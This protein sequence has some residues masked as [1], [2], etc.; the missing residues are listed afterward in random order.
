MKIDPRYSL[1]LAGRIDELRGNG[2]DPGPL[3]GLAVA[4]KDLIAVDGLGCGAGTRIDI[5][6]LLPPEGAFVRGLK[7]AG[8]VIVGKTRTTEFALGGQNL[9]HPTP[10]NPLDEEIE[11]TPGGSSSGSAVAVGEGTVPLSVG[12]DTGGSVRLPA[13][14]CGVVGYKASKGLWGSD[15][16]FPL[17]PTFDSLGLFGGNVGIIVSVVEACSDF[18]IGNVRG[19]R[20]IRVGVPREYFLDGLDDAVALGFEHVLGRLR[21]AGVPL[22]PFELPEASECGEYFSRLVPWELTQFLG[23]ERLAGAWNLIDPVAR[24]RIQGAGGL[25]ASEAERM[26]A[27]RDGL[28]DSARQR[29]QGVDCWIS[30]TA[31]CLPQPVSSLSTV[32][33]V[34]GWN[35]A[36]TR[37]TRPVN[38]LDQCALSL[39]VRLPGSRLHMGLQ[40][41]SDGMRDDRLLSISLLMEGLLD[42]GTARG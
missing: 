33:G 41:V 42:P 30:P 37:N 3:A 25:T 2:R 29:M 26:L 21:A 32:S 4:V 31:P 7:E 5:E 18:R 22:V 1:G 27:H 23:S 38:L 6:D 40:I 35:A 19:V 12:T 39:P 11:L 24:A 9:S 34:A 16:I 8:A 36:T 14:M 10:K 13:A 20:D 15:G 28:I 17:S